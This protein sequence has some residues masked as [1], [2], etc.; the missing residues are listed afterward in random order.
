MYTHVSNTGMSQLDRW[1]ILHIGVR[2]IEGMRGWYSKG[3][4]IDRVCYLYIA[5]N[6]TQ[7]CPTLV[8]PCKP[9]GA[10]G[11]LLYIPILQTFS[12]SLRL[13]RREIV[14]SVV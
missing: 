2:Q 13:T 5:N 6:T 12:L 8:D 11:K 9:E 14:V 4:K 1:E 7:M 10:P 3:L